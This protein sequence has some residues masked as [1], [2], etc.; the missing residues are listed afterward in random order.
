M[1]YRTYAMFNLEEF[2]LIT[3]DVDSIEDEQEDLTQVMYHEWGRISHRVYAD[4]EISEYTVLNDARRHYSTVPEDML[5]DIEIMVHRTGAHAINFRVTAMDYENGQ[6]TGVTLRIDTTSEALEELVECVRNSIAPAYV[7]D[8]THGGSD[9]VSGKHIIWDLGWFQLI[10]QKVET[11]VVTVVV[12]SST[13]FP[14][15]IT[16]VINTDDHKVLYTDRDCIFVCLNE[17]LGVANDPL[18]IRAMIHPEDTTHNRMVSIKRDLRR[19]AQVYGCNIAIHCV[20]DNIRLVT[21]KHMHLPTVEL[22]KMGTSIGLVT[23]HRGSSVDEA[24]DTLS[25]TGEDAY[26]D[27]ETV[28]NASNTQ[29][30]G[31]SLLR[32]DGVSVTLVYHDERVL[33]QSICSALIECLVSSSKANVY[34]HAWNG[35]RFDHRLLLRLCSNV[36]KV[37]FIVHNARR[38][39]LTATLSHS[40]KRFIL[41]D[42][43][44]MFPASLDNAATSVLGSNAMHKLDLDHNAMERAYLGKSLD[45][46][47]EANRDSISEY[48]TRDVRMLRDITTK[49]QD[50]Y[51]TCGIR[52]NSCLTRSMASYSLWTIGLSPQSKE[53]VSSIQFNYSERLAF[54]EKVVVMEDIR[55]DSIA[56]RVQ[57]I[58]GKYKHTTLLDFRSMYPSV[59]TQEQYPCG[60]YHSTSEYVPGKL[61]LYYVSIGTQTHPHVVPYRE[62]KGDAYDWSYKGVITKLITNVDMECLIE[63]GIEVEVTDG[64]VWD[65]STNYF[66]DHMTRLFN[67][68]YEY[69]SQGNEAMAEHYKHLAN[70]LTG[71][72]FQALRREYARV[73]PSHEE[74]EKYVKSYS[75]YVLVVH[76]SLQGDGQVILFFYPRKLKDAHD[77]EIQREICKGAI[78]SKPVLLTMFI[79]AYARAKLWRMWKLIEDNG[80]GKVVYCDTDSLLVVPSISPSSSKRINLSSRLKEYIGNGMGQLEIV[81]YDADASVVKPKVY[82]MRGKRPGLLNYEDRV[83]A[84]GFKPSDQVVVLPDT[85]ETKDTIAIL[86]RSG[87][88]GKRSK[89]M[90][91]IDNRCSTLSY[92]HIGQLLDNH[93]IVSISW[94]MDR[95]EDSVTKQ[96]VVRVLSV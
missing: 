82:A 66:G 34:L 45:T 46:T 23:Q 65:S 16:K 39:I 71:S 83:R 11:G 73:F 96:Y 35:S 67:K 77:L 30:Y 33:G 61:G 4:V 72:M 15:Y 84:R 70:A 56:G 37:G 94:Y 10:T 54:V 92:E 93:V 91:L 29:V 68:R 69:R 27:L 55:S 88:R 52:Y 12:G 79:Y 17:A 60:N 2:E 22:V 18:K 28:S 51:A 62:T 36:F 42:P 78:G 64:I 59:A 3:S 5:R 57:L 1:Y 74:A 80:Y 75:R 19:I 49:L 47:I 58:R 20:D 95:R 13:M 76:E 14:G 90:K 38:D 6:E 9:N 81:L 26:Y 53:D 21:S 7:G 86:R 89:Y 85:Q 31:F 43:C 24:E 87:W 40:D 32:P 48:I 41:R 50:M 25:H 8:D 44:K 63:S